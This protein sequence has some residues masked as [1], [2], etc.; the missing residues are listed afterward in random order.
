MNESSL[1]ETIKITPIL[2]QPKPENE[3]NEWTEGQ[4]EKWAND[5]KIR[6]EIL[7]NILP[8][9]GQVLSQLYNMK[10]EAPEFFYKSITSNKILP[11]RD[12]AQFMLKLETLFRK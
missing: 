1:I 6:Q 10:K 2:P 4:V 5:C 7:E 8:C 9:N 3:V 11:T 12:I